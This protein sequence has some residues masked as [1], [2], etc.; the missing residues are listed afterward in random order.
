MASITTPN[1][2]R[3]ALTLTDAAAERI[4]TLIERSEKPVLGLRVGVSNKGCSGMS[5]SIEY[6][7]E[8]KPFEDKVEDKGVRLYIDP[9]ALMFIVGSEMDYREDKLQAGFVFENPNATA[10]CGCGESFT[11]NQDA[12]QIT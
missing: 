5:Y 12:A 2:I 11:V 6:V 4:K 7:T 10:H 1:Q 3:K 9:M 8:E